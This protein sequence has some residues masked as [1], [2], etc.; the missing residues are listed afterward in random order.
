MSVEFLD[1]TRHIFPRWR[2]FQSTASLGELTWP[3]VQEEFDT[4]ELDVSLANAV[5]EWK[6]DPSLWKGLDLL[7]TATVSNRLD[8]FAGLVAE[9][10]A[11]PRTPKAARAFFGESQEPTRVEPSEGSQLSEETLRREVK[12]HRHKVISTPKD[13]VEWVELARAFTIAGQNEKGRRAILAALQLAPNNRF[14]LRSAARFFIHVGEPDIA[15]ALL[16]SARPLRQDPW[17]LASEIAI[18]DSLG[19]SSRHIRS[20]RERLEGDLPASV[21]T[22]LAAALGSLEAESGNHR[23]ARKF[24]R[25]SLEQAN[26][27]SVAQ[28]RWLNRVHLDEAVD[29]SNARP[30]LLHEA[31]AKASFY[32]GDFET[33]RDESLCWLEDQPFASA[34]AVLSSY[35]L[36]DLFAD[37]EAGKRVAE[38][39]LVANQDDLGLLNN[40]AVCLMELGEISKAEEVVDRLRAAERGAKSSAIHKAT[41]GMLAFRK[42][43]PD[44]GRKLYFEAI[45]EANGEGSRPLAARAAFH[46]AIEELVAGTDQSE[47]AVKRISR[48]D[49]ADE[50]VE[51]TRLLNRVISLLKMPEAGSQPLISP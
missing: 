14:V 9:L 29:V 10:R 13:P 24:L 47:Q 3:A 4:S 40:L 34:P 26:E 35:I 42:G 7:G 6:A 12:L 41:F 45:E 27:N 46:L 33:A 48:L 8:D 43:D 44:S 50:F 21:L 23:L 37:W 32:R 5:V 16:G 38:R 18:A 28:I 17:L 36:A 1:K 15:Q 51:S 25:R 11:N 22:E 31:N 49:K 39:G 30:P 2:S 20:A 19:K